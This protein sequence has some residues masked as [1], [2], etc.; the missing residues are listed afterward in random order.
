MECTKLNCPIQVGTVIE[1][2][3]D[4]CPWRTEVKEGD[5]ISRMAAHEMVNGLQEWCITLPGNPPRTQVGYMSDA[6][7]FGLDRLPA[8][9]AAPV[10]H[11]Q[12]RAL[13]DGTEECTNCGGLCPHEEN[14]NGDVI[15]NFDCTYCPWC[16]AKMDEVERQ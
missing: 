6:V 5:L 4:N 3:D 1:N 15:F 8:V 10:V 14:Y 9:E 16:G 7:R 11:A 2:C 13:K 12:W